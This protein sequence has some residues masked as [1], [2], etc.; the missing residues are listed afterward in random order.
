MIDNSEARIE[1]ILPTQAH[2][3][4]VEHEQEGES[5]FGDEELQMQIN[6]LIGVVQAAPDEHTKH[7]AF[8]SLIHLTH[9]KVVSMAHRY[10]HRPED[11]DAVAQEVHVRVWRG[12]EKF[13]G[14]AKYS[15]WLYRIVHNESTRYLTRSVKHDNHDRLYQQYDN[16]QND[17]GDETGNAVHLFDDSQ[18]PED[19][20]ETA[21]LR[22][23]IV[24]SLGYLSPLVRQVVVLRTIYDF[25]HQQIAKE[26]GISESASKVRLH[27]GLKH[28]RDMCMKDLSGYQMFVDATEESETDE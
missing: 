25:S 19:A 8:T 20:A 27:R 22:E 14:D 12:L 17:F 15:T 4:F 9:D 24:S 16:D 2:D 6:D 28:L 10:M 26:L 21:E 11:A 13:R 1:Q 18:S 23:K 7:E 5:W 3:D